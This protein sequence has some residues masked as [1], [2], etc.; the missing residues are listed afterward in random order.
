M[1][2]RLILLIPVLLALGCSYASPIKPA[3]S[4]ESPFWFPGW[5]EPE[6]LVSVVPQ[7]EQFRISHRGATGFVTVATIRQSA[8]ARAAEYCGSKGRAMTAIS[9]QTSSH[10]HILGNFPRVEIVFVCTERPVVAEEA[11]TAEDPYAKLLR[12]KALLDAG[13][14]SQDEYDREK[15]EVLDR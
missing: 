1:T 5:G 9:E 4:S 10:P 7:G 6:Q 8:Q 13:A 11:T 12:L 14:I 3:A 2:T 15:K